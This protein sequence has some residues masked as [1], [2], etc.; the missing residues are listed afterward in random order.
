MLV[1]SVAAIAVLAVWYVDA[2]RAQEAVIAVV[3]ARTPAQVQSVARLLQGSRMLS[4]DSGPR[5][6]HAYLL[7][8]VG[9]PA[10]AARILR[11]VV[12]REPR[13]LL[14]WQ[15]LVLADPARAPESRRRIAVLAPPTRH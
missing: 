14:A 3:N 9:R 13:N 1:V 8:K 11:S 15:Y 2:H 6:A 4:P 12:A 5:T 10:E 7:I